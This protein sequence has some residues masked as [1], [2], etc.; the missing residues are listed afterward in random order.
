MGHTDRPSNEPKPCSCKTIPAHGKRRRKDPCRYPDR[1]LRGTPRSCNPGALIS[2]SPAAGQRGVVMSASDRFREL[3]ERV[4]QGE[5]N[6]R[7]A[8]SGDSAKLEAKAD[9]ARK[10]ADEHAAQFAAMAQKT[11]EQ[12]ESH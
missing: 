1:V 8:A 12:A 9:E 2:I 4:E 5:S 6:I 11:S 7:A 3:R 10:A